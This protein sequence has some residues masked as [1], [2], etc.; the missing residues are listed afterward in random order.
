MLRVVAAG[1]AGAGY[2]V[3]IGWT[4]PLGQET[5]M[6][7][8]IVAEDSSAL[9]YKWINQ[10]LFFTTGLDGE[11]H[12]YLQALR[13][14]ATRDAGPWQMRAFYPIAR[15]EGG[16]AVRG[17]S[18]I[19]VPQDIKPG[20]KFA[21]LTF[22]GATSFSTLDLGVI[23][24]AGV[25]PEDLIPVPCGSIHGL[26]DFIMD[27]RADVAIGVPSTPAWYE[28][29]SSPHGLRWIDFNSEKDP[30]GAK[31]FLEHYPYRSFG[32]MT[33][34]VPSAVGTWSFIATLPYVT[35]TDNPEMVYHIVKW[36][37]ENHDKYKDAH[38]WCATM[39]VDNLMYISEV[40]YVPL[41]DGTVK[42]LRE[43][44]KWTD[45]HEA[46]RQQNIDLITLWEEA[47]QAA[48]AAADEQGI[49][50]DPLD[51]EWL[52]FWADASKDLTTFKRFTSFP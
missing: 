46:R 25:D 39:T 40:H 14:N 41:H 30:E 20:M 13:T 34:G 2:A 23:A 37:A 45:A 4:A 1:L 6:N 18:D 11:A 28:A 42:Y 36:L 50:V 51:E 3:G 33:Q 10:G 35:N 27:G 52:E 8:R 24:W 12:E 19:Y 29:E 5:G 48:L 17:D 9:R 22:G 43:I 49:T 31:R 38:P 21:Y 26:T 15:A 7:V 32:P 16:Y 47:Y 44:G